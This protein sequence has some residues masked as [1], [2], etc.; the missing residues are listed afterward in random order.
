MMARE[1]KGD[2]FVN[3]NKKEEDDDETNNGE[4]KNNMKKGG[5]GRGK[6][7]FLSSKLNVITALGIN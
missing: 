4:V 5:K 1:V 6:I 3:I 2:F 7:F